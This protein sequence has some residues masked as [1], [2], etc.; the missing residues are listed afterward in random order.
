MKHLH[1]IY[2]RYLKMNLPKG[3]STFLWGARK[4]GKSFYLKNHFPD[5]VYYNLLET[6]LFFKFLKEPHLLREEVQALDE[7]QLNFPIIIDEIQK[8]PFLLD[9]VHWLIE[10]SA[11]Y[12]ILCGSSAR[13]LKREGVNLLGG[14]AWSYHFFSLV[15]PEIPNF[16]LLHALNDGLVPSHYDAKYWKKTVKAYVNDYLK[17]EIKA[18]SLV[19]NL[20]AFAQFLDV[21]A[22]SNGE[23]LNYANLSRDCGVDAKTIK[24]YYQILVDTLLGYYILPYKN[25]IKRE[26]LVATPKFYYFDVGVVNSLTKRAIPELKGIDAGKAFEHYIFMELWAYKALNDLDF[27]IHFWRTNGGL[28]VDFVLGD[29]EIAIEV[30]ISDQI[31][32]ADIK[33]LIAFD[34]EY[35]PKRAIVV[36][37]A[38]RPRKMSLP[39]GQSIDIMPWKTFLEALWKGGLHL[40]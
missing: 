31:S 28:E 15:Y 39:S 10:N 32:S 33:G 22:F 18:E 13:K 5:S 1:V 17:E 30:K 35:N 37:T 27:D 14:R 2:H 24:D 19:R 29:A 20:R 16:D 25:K 21:A 38:S 6:D 4:T 36:N 3:Q 11:A 40:S 34:Q 9:E 8:I 12:F 7:A 26:D 23:I